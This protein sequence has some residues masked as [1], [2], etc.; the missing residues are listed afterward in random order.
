M[1][2]CVVADRW[3]GRKRASFQVEETF[4]LSVMKPLAVTLHGSELVLGMIRKGAWLLACEGAV[5][6]EVRPTEGAN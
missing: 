4:G 6:R 5:C 3:A 1:M 2:I